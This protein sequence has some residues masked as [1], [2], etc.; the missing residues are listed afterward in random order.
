MQSAHREV[1]RGD[2]LRHASGGLRS[3]AFRVRSA[4]LWRG[5]DCQPKLLPVQ[6]FGGHIVLWDLF[7]A[8]FRHVRIGCI[9]NAFDRFGLEK[10]PLL[11]QFFDAL[12]ACLRDIRQPLSVSGLAG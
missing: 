2:A 12:G 1:L 9:F 8:H 11:D 3:R 7:R 10:L 6:V 4:A 5:R